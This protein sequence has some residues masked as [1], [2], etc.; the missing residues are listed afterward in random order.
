MHLCLLT[1]RKSRSTRSLTLLVEANTANVQKQPVRTKFFDCHPASPPPFLVICHSP[2]H[3]LYTLPL[4]LTPVLSTKLTM[5]A[6]LL[7]F[8]TFA[9]A[10][11]TVLFQP[12]AKCLLNPMFIK[13]F[14]TV[15]TNTSSSS[16]S[17]DLS[18]DNNDP[19][20]FA[21]SVTCTTTARTL[22]ELKAT[23]GECEASSRGAF[24]VYN[25]NG[26]LNVALDYLCPTNE[27]M[28]HIVV[29]NGTV[30]VKCTTAFGT[31]TCSQNGGA[32][33]TKL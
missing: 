2:R 16:V 21:L 7:L 12:A 31:Q 13:D 15:T 29:F 28:P 9:L 30:P 11:Q 18:V 27:G 5:I 10:Q 4:H 23:S 20:G 17:F 22:D 24:F 26:I 19:N 1:L 32:Q 6:R 14:R 25:P 3:A 8:A 33:L